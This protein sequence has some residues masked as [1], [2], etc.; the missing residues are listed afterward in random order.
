MVESHAHVGS[1]V[2]RYRQS[3]HVDI[4]AVVMGWIQIGGGTLGQSG[5]NH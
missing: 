5:P 2:A 1:D 4:M 3:R